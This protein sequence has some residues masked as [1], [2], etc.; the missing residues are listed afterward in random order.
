MKRLWVWCV[1]LP[2]FAAT[3]PGRYIVELSTDPVAAHVAPMGKRGLRSQAAASHRALIHAEH[4]RARAALAKNQAT[5]L[6][7]M[8]TVVNALVV[9]DTGRRG[10]IAGERPRRE[11]RARGADLPPGARSCP[12]LA[13]GAGCLE[14]GGHRQCRRR[15]QDRLHR[16]RH[17]RRPS[18]LPG[19]VSAHAGRFSAGQRRLPI[20]PTPATRSSWRAAMPRCCPRTIPIHRRATMW[21]TA[22]PPRWPPRA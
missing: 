2:V 19:S 13:Q 17:R 20:W 9:A 6:D 10:G 3:V 7:S 12:A 11:E 5:V 4:D 16:H 18:G 8:D 22:P 1:C 14:H 21:G 15:D